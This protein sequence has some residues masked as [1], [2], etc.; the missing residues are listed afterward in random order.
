VFHIAMDIKPPTRFLRQDPLGFSPV[1][2]YL[3]LQRIEIARF[4]HRFP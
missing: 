3:E 2:A 1:E 4:I